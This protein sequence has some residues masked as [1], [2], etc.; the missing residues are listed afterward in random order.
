MARVLP[1]VVLR[2]ELGGMLS[3]TV[4][5][6]TTRLGRFS[7]AVATRVADLKTG[8]CL[9]VADS[10][11]A[12]EV[13]EIGELV[14]RLSQSGLLEYRLTRGETDEDLVVIE[15]QV[16]DYAPCI[17]PV[18]GGD[19]TCPVAFRLYATARAPHRVGIAVC[20]RALPSLQGRDRGVHRE[21]VGAA[22]QRKS[23]RQA[24]LSRPGARLP[25][26][27]TARSSSSSTPQGANRSVSP[28]ATAR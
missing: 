19:L 16:R 9:D 13:S 5:R 23:R 27:R 1:G 26:A 15:P 28:K 25:P 2:A 7:P 12:D 3:V 4:D 18:R 24:R 8:L 22:E 21:P 10:L 14:R 6:H 17:S 20:G 11:T